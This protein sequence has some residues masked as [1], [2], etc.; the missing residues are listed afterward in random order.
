M[1]QLSM[2]GKLIALVYFILMVVSPQQSFACE[3]LA[4]EPVVETVQNMSDCHKKA[5]VKGSQGLDCMLTC[6]HC[7]G[8]VASYTEVVTPASASHETVLNH[9]FPR[10]LPPHNSDLLRPPIA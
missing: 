5:P 7:A 3:M 10:I 4:P 9:G 1:V 2:L 6:M 8:S